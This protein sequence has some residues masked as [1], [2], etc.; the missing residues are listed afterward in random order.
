MTNLIFSKKRKTKIVGTRY[1]R[2]NEVLQMSTHLL[3]FRGNKLCIL[4]YLPK[5]YFGVMR[6]VQYTDML[7]YFYVIHLA[8][9]CH[10]NQSH[11]FAMRGSLGITFFG[12]LQ[13]NE[14]MPIQ[15][16]AIFHDL[17]GFRPGL[18]QTGLNSYRRCY[19]AL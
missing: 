2:L 9:C 6:E 5:F 8:T 19:Y 13:N 10:K 7:T 3:C 4:L 14:K 18:T 16:L 1:N 17:R 12:Y 11:N 15:Y